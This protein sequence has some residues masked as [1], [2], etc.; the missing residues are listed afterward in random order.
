MQHLLLLGCAKVVTQKQG[1][2]LKDVCNEN[3]ALPLQP[4]RPCALF[5][6]V[7]KL[8]WVPVLE[9]ATMCSMCSCI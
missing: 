4:T 2:I 7:M 1:F 6:Q 5:L 3:A 8:C 9:A